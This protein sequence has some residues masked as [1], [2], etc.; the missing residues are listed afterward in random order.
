MPTTIFLPP[1]LFLLDGLVAA[2]ELAQRNVFAF[3]LR[4]R[5]GKMGTVGGAVDFF[6]T[7]FFFHSIITFYECGASSVENLVISDVVG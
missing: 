7:F 4:R 5:C 2:K 1:A 3:D 6:M